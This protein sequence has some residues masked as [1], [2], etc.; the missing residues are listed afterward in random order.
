MNYSAKKIWAIFLMVSVTAFPGVTRMVSLAALEKL[1][2]AK[3]LGLIAS[4]L[5]IVAMFVY[6]SAIG[7]CS[8][9][10]GRVSRAATLV[11]AHSILL[12]FLFA[13]LPSLLLLSIFLGS[14]SFF[15]IV[16]YPIWAMVYLWGFSVYQFARHFF[17]GC[18]LIRALFL[19][20]LSVF[21]AVL[22]LTFLSF[23]R[24][25]EPQ[26]V[27]PA[28]FSLIMLP[29]MCYILWYQY[30]KGGPVFEP[31]R[32]VF[33]GSMMFGFSNLAGGG[34]YMLL[35]PL[36]LS[37]ASEEYAAL[38]G[39]AVSVMVFVTLFSRALTNYYLP[40]MARIIKVGEIQEIVKVLIPFRKYLYCGL[41]V[42]AALLCYGAGLVS[43]LSFPELKRLD[44][45][46]AIFVMLVI[47]FS[48][49]QLSMPENALLV[50][51][52]RA[53]LSAKMNSV[54]FLSFLVCIFV[55]MAT[56]Q[57]GA[58]AILLIL[59]SLTVLQA[60]KAIFLFRLAEKL[61]SKKPTIL[62]DVI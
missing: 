15:D 53:E 48:V 25:L 16:Q 2:G 61:I 47:S 52:E 14:L 28:S 59:M 6:F 43:D 11:S 38:L 19:V 37:L 17:F 39:L 54:L 18:K 9:L 27:I 41:P 5:S 55:V 49:G 42:L 36:S 8:L 20:E 35:V 58:T 33:K 4:D 31:Q 12:G 51:T 34:L 57:D 21:I 13:S 29:F 1:F 62:G 40:E 30:T 24:A 26:G 32:R 22:M 7:W 50:A 44:G 56:K 3:A 45:S 23:S 60:C 10:I 46:G